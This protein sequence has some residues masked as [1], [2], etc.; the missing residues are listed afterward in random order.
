MGDAAFLAP[1]LET[2]SER[3][4]PQTSVV[5]RATPLFLP[6]AP[7]S[8]RLL[9]SLF[10]EETITNEGAFDDQINQWQSRITNDE[11][12]TPVLGFY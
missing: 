4:K 8:I 7:T 12:K 11:M 5:C 9:A 2:D 1:D 6:L 10:L 3:Q